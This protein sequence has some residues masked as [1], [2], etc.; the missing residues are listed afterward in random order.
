[1]GIL[2]SSPG[3]ADPT[4]TSDDEDLVRVDARGDVVLL[5]G[6]TQLERVDGPGA[7]MSALAVEFDGRT[8]WLAVYWPPGDER[9][10]SVE[11]VFADEQ[12]GRSFDD[13]VALTSGTR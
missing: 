10:W 12:Q 11:G 2:E 7:T 8:R 5:E 9:G 13:F 4:R 6:V 1:M 3:N